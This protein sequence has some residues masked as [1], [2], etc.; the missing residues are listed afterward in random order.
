M[1]WFTSVGKFK[2]QEAGFTLIESLVSITLISIILIG[3]F[4]VFNFTIRSYK[5]YIENLEIEHGV[6]Y[7]LRY[8]EKRLREFNQE[9]IIFDSEKNLFI[10]ERHNG[11]KAYIDLSGRVSHRG[12][13]LLYFYRAT[14]QVRVNKN[15]ENNVLVG[16][17]DDIIVRELV[18]GKLIEIEVIASKIK[19]SNKIELGL[20]YRKE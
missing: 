5:N 18:E 7:T 13:T 10:G 8:I 1:R 6:N 2:N 15:Q 16:K 11:Q 14:R 20:N 17:I 3:I 19:Y 4:S 12:N 9:N